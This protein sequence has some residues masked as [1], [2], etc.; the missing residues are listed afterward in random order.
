MGNWQSEARFVLEARNNETEYM[1]SEDDTHHSKRKKYDDFIEKWGF[2]EYEILDLDQAI[3]MFL[4]PRLAYFRDKTDSIP[5]NLMED[6]TEKNEDAAFLEWQ[7]ILNTICEGLHL[8]IE[9]YP[10]EFSS[11]ELELWQQAKKYLF[12]YFEHLWF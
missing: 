10:T 6:I 9:K 1:F 11:A 7:K 2:S 5:N 3:A 4:L 12:D 8:Y